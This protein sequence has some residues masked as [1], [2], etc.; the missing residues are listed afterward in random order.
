MKNILFVM[1]HYDDEA[2]QLGTIVKLLKAGKRVIIMTICGQD[3]R[4]EISRKIELEIDKNHYDFYWS[5]IAFRS[6]SLKDNNKTINKITKVVKDEIIT[7]NIDT[8]FYPYQND[9]H[10][11]HQIVAKSCNLLLRPDRLK[12]NEMDS[13]KRVYQCYTPGSTEQGCFDIRE[14]NK[15][16]DINIDVVM[17]NYALQEYSKH[18]KGI[19]SRD[20]NLGIKNYFGRYY[21]YTYANIY[22]TILD[23]N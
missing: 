1:T 20:S 19:T 7:N 14:F 2:F 8:I 10:Y 17:E 23:I 16:F 12:N 11:E 6:L 15:V 22:K 3:E 4:E 13:I 9:F 18:V 21:G 5:R